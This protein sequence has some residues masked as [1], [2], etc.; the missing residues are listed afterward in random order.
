MRTME[1]SIE[2]NGPMLEVGRVYEVKEF[3]T[4][5]YTYMIEDALGMSKPYPASERLK[6]RSG[7][8]IEKK[9]TDRFKI[10]V[11]EFDE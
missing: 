10:A 2:D 4:S 5:F 1:F 11:L 9:E 6:S 3:E 7:K 8:V